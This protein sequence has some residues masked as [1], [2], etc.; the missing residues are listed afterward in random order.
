MWLF[1]GLI[2][3]QIL[4]AILKIAGPLKQWHWGVILVPGIIWVGAIVWF[5]IA[6]CGVM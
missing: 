1:W 5:S 2:G 6:F 4:L 3:L